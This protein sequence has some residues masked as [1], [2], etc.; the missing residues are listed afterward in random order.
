MIFEFQSPTKFHWCTVTLICLH[1]VQRSFHSTMAELSHCDKACIAQSLK[2]LL[3]GP[4]QQKFA[5]RWFKVI[6]GWQEQTLMLSGK[7]TLYTNL[8]EFHR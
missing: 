5:D 8:K 6:S 4:L 1:T 7:Q 3:S 2:Y